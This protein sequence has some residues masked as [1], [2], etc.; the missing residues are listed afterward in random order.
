M[1]LC[2]G[3]GRNSQSTRFGLRLVNRLNREVGELF[4]SIEISLQLQS[5][6]SIESNWSGRKFFVK[7]QRDLKL[8]DNSIQ[9]IYPTR[10]C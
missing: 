3:G 4:S 9:V 5:G 8:L 6:E 1:T 7:L 2:I 10:R